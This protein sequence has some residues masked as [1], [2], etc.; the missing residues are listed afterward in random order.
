MA[1]QPKWET[2]WDPTLVVRQCEKRCKVR[3]L[4]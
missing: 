3:E 4:L 2:I 1:A